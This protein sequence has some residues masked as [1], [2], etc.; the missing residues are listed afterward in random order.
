M[1]FRKLLRPYMGSFESSGLTTSS[2]G[3]KKNLGTRL[4]VLK[5]KLS[6]H[7]SKI[8]KI[9]A[10]FIAVQTMHSYFFTPFKFLKMDVYL[11]NLAL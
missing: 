7:V 11:P 1:Y 8:P 6:N 4:L 2:L 5:I 9:T 3:R 10:I